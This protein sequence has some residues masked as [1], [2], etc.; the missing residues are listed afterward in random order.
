MRSTAPSM[1][2]KFTVLV[3]PGWLLTFANALRRSSLFSSDDFPTFERPTN[4]T[5]GRSLAGI[6]ALVPYAP[7]NF[8]F[9]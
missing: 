9:W 2:K 1:Q 3:L 4:A 5:S 8:T 7:V 6:C